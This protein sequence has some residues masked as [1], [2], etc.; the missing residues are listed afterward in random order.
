MRATFLAH[1]TLLDLIFL[2]MFVEEYD[3]EDS[4]YEPC[5]ASCYFHIPRSTYYSKIIC[6]Q[7]HVI[8]VGFEVLTAVVMKNSIFWDMAPCGPLK[9]NRYLGGKWKL[10]LQGRRISKARNK[11]AGSKLCNTHCVLSCS[12]VAPQV[13]H[14]ITPLL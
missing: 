4:Q 14:I 2:I 6:F 8:Y 13:F 10:H 7:I 12:R 9:V 5:T 3:Y 1:F 11:Q